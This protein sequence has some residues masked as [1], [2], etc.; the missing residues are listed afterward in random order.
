MTAEQEQEFKEEADRL[1]HLSQ[2]D[3]QRFIAMLRRDAGN[4][5]IPKRDRDYARERADA[6]ERFLNAKARGK[7]A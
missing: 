4:G 2:D 1:R 6:L 3:Q 7:N 5:K